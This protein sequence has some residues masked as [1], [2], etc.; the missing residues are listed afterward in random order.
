MNQCQV[1]SVCHTG[2]RLTFYTKV[3]KTPKYIYPDTLKKQ[4]KRWTVFVIQVS[5]YHCMMTSLYLCNMK[6]KDQRFKVIY[7]LRLN[8]Q[9]CGL[10]TV[11]VICLLKFHP[12][13]NYGFEL[14]STV[15]MLASLQLEHNKTCSFYMQ[16]LQFVALR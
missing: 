4:S 6:P 1:D 9:Q 7:D 2:F 12:G 13:G 10:N 14:I 16:Y 15:L 5:A 8:G 11:C 3:L